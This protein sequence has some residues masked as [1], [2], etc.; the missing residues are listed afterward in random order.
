MPSNIEVKEK[1]G[2]LY[3]LKLDDLFYSS[4]KDS[5]FFKNPKSDLYFD[6]HEFIMKNCNLNKTLKN[7][8]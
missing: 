5:K 7:N 8:N 2:D 3:G 6:F 4:I 1:F